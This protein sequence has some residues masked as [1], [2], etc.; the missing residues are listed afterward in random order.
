MKILMGWGW[1][2]KM[3]EENKKMMPVFIIDD[4]VLKNIFEGKN[5]GKSNDLLKKLKKANDEQ[6]DFGAFTTSSSF[7]RAIFLSDPESKIVSI[8]K[9]LSFV[10]V[11]PSFADPKDGKAVTKEFLILANRISRGPRQ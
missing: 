6:K 7:F 11:A 1:M 2:I 4:S 8:Q 10:T 3:P 9:I 5:K